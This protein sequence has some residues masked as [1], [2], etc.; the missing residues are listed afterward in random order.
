[1]V[2]I[3]FCFSILFH[4]IGHMLACKVFGISFKRP[5]FVI[6]GFAN[7]DVK[8]NELSNFQKILI[9]FMGPCFN[10]LLFII[11]AI[12]NFYLSD[13]LSILNLFLG[14]FNMLPIIPLDGGNILICVLLVGMDT[15]NAVKFGCIISKLCLILLS[16]VVSV[17][18]IFIQNFSFVILV[19]ILWYIY[20]K[21]EKELEL[22][23]L[24]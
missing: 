7:Y 23:I 8:L 9:L 12:M 19:G 6:Y 1:M 20:I 10:F 21:E 4:E 22:I 16:F 13:Y 2:Y 17:A 11:F 18:I 5:K 24:D 15:K 3:L 14:L